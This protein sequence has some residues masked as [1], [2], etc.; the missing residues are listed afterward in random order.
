MFH[1]LRWLLGFGHP[2]A[3]RTRRVVSLRLEALED[4]Q[5][6]SG[7]ACWNVCCGTMPPLNVSTGAV[8][9]PPLTLPAVTLPATNPPVATPPLTI[10][11]PA[12]YSNAPPSPQTTLGPDAVL[13]TPV[14]TSVPLAMHIHPHLSIFINGQPQVIP[15]DIGITSTGGAFPIHTHDASGTLHVESPVAREF[16]LQ[17]F[18]TIWGQ[19][20]DARDILDQHTDATHQ[21]AVTMTV[22]GQ[23]S[24]AFGSL[25][26]RD[27]DNIVINAVVTDARPS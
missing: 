1:T 13:F 6:P 10:T 16:R 21:V 22:D 20:F 9:Q 11:P 19:S 14:S 5:V 25:V 15:A 26:L 7:D 17:D 24:A 3:A 12:S 27:Q 23:P 2:A 4:R 8:Q 18:F